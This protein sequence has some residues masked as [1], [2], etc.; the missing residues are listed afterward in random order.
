MTNL[1]VI[2]LHPKQA[3]EVKEVPNA[4]ES[5]QSIVGGYIESVRLK[6]DGFKY[7]VLVNE[8]GKLKGL[9]PNLVWMGDVLVGPAVFTK[10]DD[11]GAFVSLDDDDVVRVKTW[12][13]VSRFA[14][15]DWRGA[16]DPA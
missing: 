16:F 8:E 5:L 7:V 13:T 2:I 12:A 10:S 15:G 9:Q 4:L 14:L 11:E 1:R 3:P 6:A